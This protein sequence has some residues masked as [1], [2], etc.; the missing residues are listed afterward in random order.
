MGNEKYSF[1]AVSWCTQKVYFEL[2]ADA[3]LQ[4]IE[5]GSVDEIEAPTDIMVYENGLHIMSVCV[6]EAETDH[7]RI[8]MVADAIRKVK[9]PDP[10]SAKVKDRKIFD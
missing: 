8:K 7:E 3:D 9:R 4:D 10:L 1:V 5:Y 6:R 2:D